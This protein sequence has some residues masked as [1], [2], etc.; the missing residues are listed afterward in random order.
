MPQSLLNHNTFGLSTTCSSLKE[1][2]CVEQLK[3]ILLTLSNEKWIHIGEGSN[4]LFLTEHFD[5]TVLYSRI[6]GIKV[7]ETVRE[8]VLVTVGAGEKWDDFV[9]Y[10]VSNGY[11][12]IENLS[13]IPGQVGASAIQNIGAYGVEVGDLIERVHTIDTRTLEERIFMK[14][15]CEYDYRSSLFKHKFKNRYVVTHVVFRLKTKFI[16]ILSHKA[17]I[18]ELKKNKLSDNDITASDMRKSVIAVRQLRIPDPKVLGNAGSLFMNPIISQQQADTFLRLHSQMPHHSVKNGVKL[19]AAWLIDQSGW[20][21][22]KRGKVGVHDLQP[23]VLV[24]YGEASGRDIA[25]LAREIQ[26]DV[27]RKFGVSLIPEVLYIS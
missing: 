17:L 15:E 18:D 16:P 9:D 10:C 25:N 8:E 20:K 27:H 3:Q 22:K 21:G 23:L 4:L 14:A 5:G 7:S 26:E 1:Y 12:G 24:N 13:F 19:S 6:K 11:Y 2:A